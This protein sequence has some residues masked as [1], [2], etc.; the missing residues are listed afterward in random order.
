MAAATK[1]RDETLA[2]LQSA[3]DTAET[4]EA[5]AEIKY[6]MSLVN[7]NFETQKAAA[8]AE[9]TKQC[10]EMADGIA[11]AYPEVAAKMKEILGKQNLIESIMEQ[12]T[13]V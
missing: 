2:N 12:L 4:V 13:V 8:V 11:A 6:Q 10:N 9:Y 1:Q 3:L 7:E 5:K